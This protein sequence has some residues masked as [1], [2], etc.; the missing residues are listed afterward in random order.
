MRRYVVLR[1]VFPKAGL[2]LIFGSNN[3]E[4]NFASVSRLKQQRKPEKTE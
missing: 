3:K 1:F 4:H 2:Q